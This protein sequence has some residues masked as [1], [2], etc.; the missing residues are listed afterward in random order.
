AE[1][2]CIDN[3]ELTSYK[4]KLYLKNAVGNSHRKLYAYYLPDSMRLDTQLYRVIPEKSDNVT[5][6]FSLKG[7][8]FHRKVLELT[9]NSIEFLGEMKYFDDQVGQYIYDIEVKLPFDR[10][11][12]SGLFQK[13]KNDVYCFKDYVMTET[14][15]EALTNYAHY[16]FS[17]SEGI[18]DFFFQF[19]KRSQKSG[20]MQMD[21]ID[22]LVMQCKGIVIID[23]KPIVTQIIK[24]MLETST[25]FDVYTSND[26]TEA[27]SYIRKIMP[28]LV[29][30]DK[31][32]PGIGGIEIAE[33]LKRNKE[34][35]KIPII[36]M[37]AYDDVADFHYLKQ[38]GIDGYMVKPVDSKKI[39]S[40]I[41]STLS[42]NSQ[43][44]KITGKA[45]AVYSEDKNF[46][47][48]IRNLLELKGASALIVNSVNSIHP[49]KNCEYGFVLMKSM[50]NNSSL[51]V[52]NAFRCREEF[53]N[54]KVYIIPADDSESEILKE[55]AD[56]MLE[57]LPRNF[58]QA[59]IITKIQKDMDGI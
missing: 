50:I 52:L 44:Q 43:C 15:I 40:M 49:D 51:S 46:C 53:A 7:K 25:D 54:A 21:D 6:D 27:V 45:F 33:Q 17:R 38:I 18:E 35:E 13:I 2:Q 58:S 19:K 5:I 24:E 47:Q 37:T 14:N 55:L 56:D 9:K 57:I 10:I 48:T 16:Y 8:P 20:V 23:D 32:M 4:F 1:F 22:K 41:N 12:I 59:D 34:T 31:N 36:I 42:K 11:K 26:S 30:L 39:I 3:F 28:S 29:I